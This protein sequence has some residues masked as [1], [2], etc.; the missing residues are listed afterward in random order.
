VKLDRAAQAKVSAKSQS[1]AHADERTCVVLH[2]G[3]D[4]T[5]TAI[6]A[7][8][9]TY[10]TPPHCNAP[11]VPTTLHSGGITG[12][13]IVDDHVVLAADGHALERVSLADG[14]AETL[15]SAE[16]I[17][18]VHVANATAYFTSNHPVGP[19]T[20]QGKQPLESA[21]FSLPLAGGDTTLLR[22][23]FAAQSATSDATS[24]YFA[25]VGFGEILVF[26]PPG[27]DAVTFNLGRLAIRALTTH[28][29]DV[30]AAAQ[31]YTTPAGDRGAIARMAKNGTA[32][33]VLVTTAGLPNDIAVDDQAIY[34]LEDA[35]YGTFG[36]GH[37]AR[38]DL[39]GTHVTTLAM[40]DAS[41]LALD[42]Q[43]VYFVND[44][45]SRIPKQGGPV[46]ELVPGLEG[47]G[48]LHVS[49][50]DAVWVNLDGKA[51]SDARPSALMAMCLHTD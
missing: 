15:L 21:L 27:T 49:G 43:Y 39:D 11:S 48:Q 50:A 6:D 26:T 46:E 10:T 45:L 29:N 9:A 51:L 14:T 33:K 19:A 8:P 3:F 4:G 25:G 44:S 17:Y 37:I 30:Y 22:D 36:P 12:A 38:S 16:Y 41:A 32:A 42:A 23:R 47:A 31:D 20:P 1:A 24:A 40:V 5:G 13:A 35:P 28:A 18:G 7:T 2:I 34:W